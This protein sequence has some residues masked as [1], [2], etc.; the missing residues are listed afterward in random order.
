[1]NQSPPSFRL[2]QT[3][4]GLARNL[5]PS[6][7][8]IFSATLPVKDQTSVD[9]DL[10]LDWDRICDLLYHSSGQGLNFCQLGLGL[11][12]GTAIWIWI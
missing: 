7:F 9:C 12:L 8:A 3:L 10:N 2:S 5:L 1:V 11:G 4:S 6:E